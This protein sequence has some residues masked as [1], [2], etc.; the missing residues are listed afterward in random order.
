MDLLYN[1]IET[2]VR[3]LKNDKWQTL[4]PGKKSINRFPILLLMRDLWRLESAG[5]LPDSE[6]NALQEAEIKIGVWIED[7][8]GPVVY[9]IWNYEEL[10]LFIVKTREAFFIVERN[11]IQLIED[12]LSQIYAQLR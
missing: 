9:S 1:D 11:Q 12:H 5:E 4:S 6:I 2:K 8:Q 7:G 3:R 10:N